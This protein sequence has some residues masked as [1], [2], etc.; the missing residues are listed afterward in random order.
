MN[1]IICDSTFTVYSNSDIRCNGNYSQ[2]D[3]IQIRDH[4]SIQTQPV[5][6]LNTFTPE[7]MTQ[8]WTGLVLILLAGF[9]VRLVR[10][11][12]S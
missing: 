6:D 9:A 4:L 3:E 5:S 11:Q 1:Y 8:F 7:E 2:A 12:F 10:R